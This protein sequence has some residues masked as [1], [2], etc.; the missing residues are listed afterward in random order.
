MVLVRLC[1]VLYSPVSK[2]EL[3]GGLTS[4]RDLSKGISGTA[5]YILYT[6]T[7]QCTYAAARSDDV[8]NLTSGSAWVT[9]CT[10]VLHST[11]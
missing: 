10:S 6:V 11:L 1:V 7:V 3:F 4:N 2:A 5:S 9:F 8:G